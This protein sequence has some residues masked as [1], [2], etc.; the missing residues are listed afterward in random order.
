MFSLNNGED[1][2]KN[3]G[4]GKRIR[5]KFFS[6]PYDTQDDL[7]KCKQIQAWLKRR[8]NQEISW[9]LFGQKGNGLQQFFY[10]DAESDKKNGTVYIR[11]REPYFV[12]KVLYKNKPTFDP[13]ERFRRKAEVV[14]QLLQKVSFTYNE[15]DLQDLVMIFRKAPR[16][17]IEA[18][19]R[20]LEIDIRN[21]QQRR[22]KSIRSLGGYMHALYKKYL[23]GDRTLIFSHIEEINEA[24]REAMESLS[25]DSREGEMEDEVDDFELEIACE[26]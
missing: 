22:W 15:K 14:K 23:A 4:K 19:L 16:R 26:P 1:N 13:L 17:V 25:E 24:Y 5:R 12:T 21:R 7:K 2:G 3:L 11:I 9:L 8:C 18:L 20:T 6:T 10:I